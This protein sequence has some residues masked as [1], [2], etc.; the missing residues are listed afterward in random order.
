MKKLT[1]KTAH[2]LSF[3][4][5]IKT[6]NLTLFHAFSPAIK[7]TVS[8]TTN[9][10]NANDKRPCISACRLISRDVIST[11]DTWKVIPITKAK[12]AKSR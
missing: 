3:Y 1:L 12:Y 6:Y 8:A 2:F 4:L 10:F 9:V 11:S 5:A 7:L